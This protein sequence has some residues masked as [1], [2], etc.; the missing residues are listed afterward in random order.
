MNTDIAP[1]ENK[2][3]ILIV[4]DVPNNL[5]ILSRMLEKEGYVVILASNGPDALDI[6]KSVLPDLILLDIMMPEMD[7]FEVCTILKENSLTKEIPIVF[8]TVRDEVNDIIRGFQSGS[9]DYIKKPF[10]LLELIARINIQIELKKSRDANQKYIKQLQETNEELNR[11]K[12]VLNEL[13]ANKD[14]FFTII[15]HELRNPFQALLGLSEVLA[16][17]YQTFDTNDAREI[18]FDIKKSAEN[19]YRLLENLLEWSRIQMGRVTILPEY[20]NLKFII[21]NVI[22]L[23]SAS[24]GLKGITIT[25][26][27]EH[28][29]NVYADPNMINTVFR[30]LIS[31]AIKYTPNNSSIDV[32]AEDKGEFAEVKISDNGEGIAP[33]K[34]SELFSIAK[35]YIDEYTDDKQ[36]KGTGIGLI[37]SKELIIK[38]GGEISVEST[39]GNGCT[40]TFTLPKHNY[41]SSSTT[42][43]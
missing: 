23:L 4:D 22:G 25:N 26:H 16:N 18:A 14:K 38:N 19:L 20:E 12:N 10:N 6:T 40:F 17:N 28:D 21:N 29:I 39:P 33:E 9:V 15:A 37:L 1:V 34:L 31:N 41:S 5:K 43:Q 36:K 30:N 8:L 24:A 27:L 32:F 13:N 7:G 3:V 42:G 11:T 35:T 2:P